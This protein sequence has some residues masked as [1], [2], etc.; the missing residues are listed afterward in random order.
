[1]HEPSSTSNKGPRSKSSIIFVNPYLSA[2]DGIR[3]P[4]QTIYEKWSVRSPKGHWM[5][6][7]QIPPPTNKIGTPKLFTA[8]TH[9]QVGHSAR[10][11][12]KNGRKIPQQ[13]V[14]G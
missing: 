1:M 13:W 8:L 2:G 5:T 12:A 4:V 11:A 9:T 14:M 7:A 6:L 3:T 10:D